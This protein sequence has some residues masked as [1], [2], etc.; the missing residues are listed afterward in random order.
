MTH[1][2]KLQTP[3]PPFCRIEGTKKRKRERKRKK[4]KRKG[5]GGRTLVRWVERRDYLE[6]RKKETKGGEISRDDDCCVCCAN[7]STLF[8][9]HPGMD[10]REAFIILFFFLLLSWTDELHCFGFREERGRGGGRRVSY[11]LFFLFVYLFFF[12]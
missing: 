11:V 8:D 2:R 6:R 10:E 5:R 3:I 12:F 7:S 4:R 1:R 9:I